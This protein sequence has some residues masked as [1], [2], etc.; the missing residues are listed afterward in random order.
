M[1]NEDDE[2]LFTVRDDEGKP[3]EIWNWDV[4]NTYNVDKNF[5]EEYRQFTTLKRK[6]I[7]PYDEYAKARGL[8]WPVVKDGAGNWRIEDKVR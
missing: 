6:D 7:A 5:F 2:F 1:K 8:R 4:F 3:I